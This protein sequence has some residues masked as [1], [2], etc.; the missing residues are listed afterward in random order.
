M[1]SPLSYAEA[2]TAT[3]ID[4]DLDGVLDVI[5][6]DDHPCGQALLRGAELGLLW[7]HLWEHHTDLAGHHRSVHVANVAFCDEIAAQFGWRFA[8]EEWPDGEDW[9]H[10]DDPDW[11]YGGFYPA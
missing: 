7:A 4:P 6:P 1:P 9:G 2:M 5:D 8:S 10:N 11:V 3:T